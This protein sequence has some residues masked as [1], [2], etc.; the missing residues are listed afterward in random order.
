MARRKKRCGFSKKQAR[1]HTS[2]AMARR[3]EIIGRNPWGGY[4]HSSLG[5][6]FMRMGSVD[7]AIAEFEKAVAINPWESQFKMNLARAYIQ[8]GGLEKARQS[9]AAIFK[10]QPNL[11]EGL[12]VQAL[13]Y[14]A[15]GQPPQ[16]MRYYMRCIEAG[17]NDSIRKQAPENMMALR[18]NPNN[19]KPTDTGG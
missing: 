18:R 19:D 10:K 4:N 14:E 6:E 8:K 3:E 2:E 12:F 17:A 11:A 16:A 9:L 15:Q 1:L 5:G 13:L 7:F